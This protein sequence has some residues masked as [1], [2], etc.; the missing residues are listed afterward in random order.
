MSDVSKC[1]HSFFILPFKNKYWRVGITMP[2]GL[3]TA[4]L[5]KG[6]TGSPANHFLTWQPME[7]AVNSLRDVQELKPDRMA[8]LQTH[9]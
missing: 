4:A 8:S 5:R 6:Q 9:H 1:T 2:N 3:E 7:P